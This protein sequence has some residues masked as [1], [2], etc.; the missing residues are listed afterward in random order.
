MKVLSVTS[1][2]YPIVK[3]GGLADV[4]GALPPALGRIG[5]EMRSLVPG[6]PAVMQAAAGGRIIH[7]FP[8]LLGTPARL[9]EVTTAGLDLLVL[10]APDLYDRPGGIYLGPDG[11]DHPDNWRRYAALCIAA[12][13]IAAGALPDFRPDLVHA[14]DWQAGLVPLYLRFRGIPVPSILTVHNIAFQ[15]HFSG[16]IF[17]WLELPSAAW[18]IDG[19][20]YFQGVGFLKA[21]LANATAITTVSPTYA[22]EITTPAFGMGLDGLIRDRARVLHGIVNGIDTDVWNPETDASLA[23]TYS[24]RKPGGRL[25]NRRAVEAQ[26]GLD[27]DDAPLLVVVSRLT[28]QKG[29]DLLA[30]ASDELVGLGAKL[31][32]LGAGEAWLERAFEDCA[33]R[34]PGRI[35]VTI[36]YNEPLAHLMQ[37]GGDAIIIPSRFEPCGLTQLYGL[38]YG[39]VPVVAR[40]GGLADTVIDANIAALQAGASTGLQFVPVDGPSLRHALRRTVALFRDPKT[41]AALQRNGMRADVSWDRSAAE[42]AALYASLLPSQDLPE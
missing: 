32:V 3:T 7:E 2:I 10:D 37:G 38:R 31:A 19:L 26:F 28:W 8:A 12:S 35:G 16:D 13:E 17:T 42:Y 41:W 1:E 29:I 40:T 15:G 39:C 33:A 34:H 5:V 27:A 18:S 20:E 36:G 25:A 21:G 6:Y 23:A 11:R 14:H 24:A 30:E 4:A 9:I 22:I